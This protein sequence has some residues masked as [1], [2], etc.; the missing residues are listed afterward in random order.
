[1]MVRKSGYQSQKRKCTGQ[2]QIIN[3]NNFPECVIYASSAT[4]DNWCDSMLENKIIPAERA[5]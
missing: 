5:I 3:S 4:N 1:M 2:N